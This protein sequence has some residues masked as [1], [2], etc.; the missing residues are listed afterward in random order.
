MGTGSFRGGGKG[1][2]GVTL[3]TNPY[4]V[5]RSWKSGALPLLPLWARAAC[6]RVKPTLR[7]LTL[8]RC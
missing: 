3:T 7:Y 4:L 1:G 8:R 5:P 6:C 2:R